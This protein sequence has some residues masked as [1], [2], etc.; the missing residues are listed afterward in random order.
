MGRGPE[1]IFSQGRHTD[2]QQTHEKMF[3]ITNH[4]RNANQNHK[5][6]SLHTVRMAI[7]KKTTSNK[8]GRGYAEKGTV[9]GASVRWCHHYGEQDGGSSKN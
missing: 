1:Q 5:E 8:C 6:I 2:G 3:N 4:Q 9:G 7:I